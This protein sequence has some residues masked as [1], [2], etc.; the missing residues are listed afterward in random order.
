[1]KKYFRPFPTKTTL[2]AFILGATALAGCASE[3]TTE[4][5]TAGP[6]SAT[7]PERDPVET[8]DT[9]VGIPGSRF[10]GEITEVHETDPAPFSSA[11]IFPEQPG[12]QFQGPDGTYC[13]MY[14]E[15]DPLAMCAHEGEGD[16]N[17]VSV[18]Q[19]EPATTHNVNRI[20]LPHER[21]QVLQPGSRLVHGPV[22]CAV[23]EGEVRVMCAIDFYS[24]AVSR[25]GLEL[26]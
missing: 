25:E 13:E 21:T 17:A 2:A 3:E 19:G 11:L 4:T 15:E 14:A 7:T 16:I 26:S 6:T 10:V 8:S 12:L 5:V 20:F 24:F 18:H 22:S 23:P 9:W 1:M